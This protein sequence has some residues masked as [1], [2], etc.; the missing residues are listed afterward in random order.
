MNPTRRR[1]IRWIAA[2]IVLAGIV[3]VVAVVGF[4]RMVML[5][6]HAVMVRRAPLNTLYH[7]PRVTAENQM[8]VRSSPDLIYSACAFDLADGPLRITAP[9]TG[10][11][12]SLSCYG[13]NTNCFYV[14]NDRQVGEDGFDFVLV[15]PGDEPPTDLDAEI[16]R[17]PSTRGVLLF[18]NFAGN[19]AHIAAIETARQQAVC[20]KI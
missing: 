16:V 3:H 4:P 19:G 10:A 15:G 18:R 11:Y 9:L 12:M 14:R 6:S 5:I 7:A 8:V 1:R 2:V 17:A 13:N 20:A